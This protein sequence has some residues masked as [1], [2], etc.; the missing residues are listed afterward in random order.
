MIG[1]NSGVN[2]T[3]VRHSR[4]QSGD[5]ILWIKLL[6]ARKYEQLVSSKAGI[7]WQEEK[8]ATC[9]TALTCQRLQC[10]CRLED[11]KLKAS[12]RS[13]YG[14]KAN[15]S[16][17]H[18]LWPATYAL[19]LMFGHEPWTSNLAMQDARLSRVERTLTMASCQRGRS[20]SLLAPDDLIGAMQIPFHEGS[21]F[22]DIPEE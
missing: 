11:H 18:R 1:Q 21:F 19:P 7:F 13:S 9:M 15:G 5:S 10:S 22:G 12:R 20:Y 3:K 14:T 2:N 16:V 4:P 6:K 8:T 17:M